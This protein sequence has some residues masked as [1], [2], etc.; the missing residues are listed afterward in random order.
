MISPLFYL[1]FRGRVY[2]K[3][4][5]QWT[6]ADSDDS[7]LNGIKGAEMYLKKLYMRLVSK[8]LNMLIARSV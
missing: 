7:N 5:E 1:D 8:C 3:K 2:F 4:S 6:Q